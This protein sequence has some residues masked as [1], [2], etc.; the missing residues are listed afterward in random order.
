MIYLCLGR[1]AAVLQQVELV[2]RFNDAAVA[3]K[4]IQQGGGYLGV[5]GYARPFC[6]AQVGGYDHA[7]AAISM[8]MAIT[9][10]PVGYRRLLDH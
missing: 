6:S 2:A 3:S 1:Q 9:L 7:G 10:I 4:L 8:S 5:T